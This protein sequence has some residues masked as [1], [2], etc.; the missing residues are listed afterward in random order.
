MHN[1]EELSA[2]K[3]IFKDA[4]LDAF[5]CGVPALNEYLKRYAYLNHQSGS[6]RAYIVTRGEKRVVGFY[7]LSYGDVAHS[8]APE[9]VKKVLGKYPVPVLLIARLAVDKAE[10]GIGLGAALVKDAIL[11]AVQASDIAGLRAM[12]VHTKDG[13][14][15]AFYE[16]FGFEPSPVNQFHLYLLMKDIKKALE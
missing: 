1:K 6:S 2:V 13:K 3:P 8:E 10:Q 9:R 14:A 15:K 12:L 11:R 4:N 16:K 7:T 5:D